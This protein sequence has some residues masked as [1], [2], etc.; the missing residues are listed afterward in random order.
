MQEF[1]PCSKSTKVSLPQTCCRSSSRLTSWPARV[2]SRTRTFAGWGG[3]LIST[4]AFRSSPLLGSS[5]KIPKRSS[6]GSELPV[7]TEAPPDDYTGNRQFCHRPYR[8]A[9]A[10]ACNELA[11][12][13]GVTE[14]SQTGHYLAVGS[15]L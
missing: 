9:T 8:R 14:K 3:R 7:T 15:G 10:W 12:H 5:S 13:R 1:R 6:E 11:A 4:P 2:A